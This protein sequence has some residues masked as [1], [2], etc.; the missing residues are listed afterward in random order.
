M[1]STSAGD[2]GGRLGRIDDGS[3][4][5]GAPGAPGCTTTGFTGSGRCARAEAKKETAKTLTAKKARF[6]T[7]RVEPGLGL[8]SR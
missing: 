5:L 8:R 2:R 7:P 4:L 3:V 6:T 1:N